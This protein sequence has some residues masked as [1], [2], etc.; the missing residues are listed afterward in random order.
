MEQSMGRLFRATLF[1]SLVLALPLAAAAMSDPNPDPTAAVILLRKSCGTMPIHNCFETMEELTTTGTTGWIWTMRQPSA[2]AP[3]FV[4]IGPGEFKQFVCNGTPSTPGTGPIRGFVTLR[5]SGREQTILKGTVQGARIIDCKNLSFIDIGIQG[6]KYGVYWTGSEGGS[7][8]WS[9]VDIVGLGTNPSVGI[10]GWADALCAGQSTRSVHY[11][12]GSRIRAMQA[13]GTSPYTWAIA[14]MCAENWIFG[15]EILID[16][17]GSALAS[18]QKWSAVWIDG[19]LVEAF[20]TAIRASVRESASSPDVA[21][22]HILNDGAASHTVAPVAF[23]SHGANFGLKVT[24]AATVDVVAIRA[25]DDV[26]VHSPGTAY[27]LTP[28]GAG[29]AIRVQV[30]S[31]TPMIEAPYHWSADTAPPLLSSSYASKNGEDLFVETDCDANGCSGTGNQPHLM[32][33]STTCP[34]SNPWWD[35][36]RNMCRQ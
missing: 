7:S 8:S 26:H 31:G 1:L 23:H 27:A 6:A 13:S 35:V 2:A 30:G 16:L 24:S 9:N 5:G 15:G 19:G 14:S 21:G 36:A 20:G 3:L 34:T 11:F 22:V 17:S 25:A 29:K 10:I 28:G 18:N 33:Y 12:H 4:D 32:I